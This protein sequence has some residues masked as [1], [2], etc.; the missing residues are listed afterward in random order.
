MVTTQSDHHIADHYVASLSDAQ[1]ACIR[2]ARVLIVEG[3]FYNSINDMLL[4]GA[5]GALDE[6]GLENSV[7]TVPGALEIAPMMMIALHESENAGTP[8]DAVVALGCVIRGETGHYD[9]VAT[10][11]ARALMDLSIALGMPLGNAILTVEN[12][13]QAQVRALDKGRGAVIAALTVLA[14]KR[15]FQAKSDLQAESDAT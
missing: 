10:E 15:D 5:R 1:H 13:E 12:M 2:G 4:Q 9:I 3:R 14:F 11:S 7:L 8:F 6:L